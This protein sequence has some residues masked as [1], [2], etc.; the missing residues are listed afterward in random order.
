MMFNTIR[1]RFRDAQTLK[2]LCFSAEKHANSQ[3][4]REP[5]TEHFVL[6]ALDLPDC[7]AGRAFSL[8]GI[9]RDAYRNSIEKQ[10]L[11]A[12]SSI[13]VPSDSFS[14][15]DD[16]DFAV[17]PSRGPYRTQPSA[18]RMMDVLTREIM[19]NEQ[20]IDSSAALL[21]AHVLLAASA[22][23]RGVCARTFLD[24]GVEPA[25]L[26]KAAKLAIDEARQLAR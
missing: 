15:L 23:Q 10:Y 24:L 2:A 19:K 7:T 8:L 13:G 3:G 14:K 22:A 9:T 21:G 6:A 26:G 20:K 25:Q 17:P 5:G 12:L 4:Q 1:Q 18:Q 16:G 11:S